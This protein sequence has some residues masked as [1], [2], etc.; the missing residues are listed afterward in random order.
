MHRHSK[1]WPALAE[2]GCRAGAAPF[3]GVAVW[4]R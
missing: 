4:W 3:E 1:Q 2:A